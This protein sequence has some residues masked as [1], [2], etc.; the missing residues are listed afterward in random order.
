MYLREYCLVSLG[1]THIQSVQ[2]FHNFR[3]E[4]KATNLE[5][6]III[7]IHIYTYLPPIYMKTGKGSFCVE[8]QSFNSEE[9]FYNFMGSLLSR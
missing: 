5:L 1:N 2:F 6:Y 3:N 8:I 9:Y 4:G 7:C